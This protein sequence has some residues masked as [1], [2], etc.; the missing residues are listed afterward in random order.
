MDRL[1]A[2]HSGLGVDWGST[3]PGRAYSEAF[4]Y[5][6]IDRLAKTLSRTVETGA[7]DFEV[8]ARLIGANLRLRRYE[9][10]DLES[11]DDSQRSCR[12]HDLRLL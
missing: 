2:G 9:I 6:Q 12:R 1:A 8:W 11:G 4:S 10:E 3:K 7:R 5:P